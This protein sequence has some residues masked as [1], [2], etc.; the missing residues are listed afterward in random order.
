MELLEI[1]KLLLK[2]SI[3]IV[4]ELLEKGIPFRVVAINKGINYTPPLP[5]PIGEELQ[6]REIIVFDLVN[7]TLASG[8]VIDS[9]LRFEAGFG[10]QNVGAVVEIPLWRVTTV[11]LLSPELPLFVNPF[12]EE[13]PPTLSPTQNRL[14]LK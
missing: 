2:H 7:Y 14:V 5:S 6:K 10:P 4:R 11:V 9:T 8:E 1:K 13:E 12:S 3:Q